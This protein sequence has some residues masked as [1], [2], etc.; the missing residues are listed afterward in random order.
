MPYHV[1]KPSLVNKDITIYYRGD[2]RWSD[3][4]SERLIFDEDPTSMFTNPD[5]TNGGWS[6]AEVVSE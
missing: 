3:N 4:F 2:R 6:G 5:G 1:K